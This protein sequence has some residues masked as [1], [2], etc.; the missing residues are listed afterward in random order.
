MD[1]YQKKY[2]K[3][4]IKY[5]ILKK[6]INGGFLIRHKRLPRKNKHKSKHKSKDEYK[7]KECSKKTN[8]TNQN[9]KKFGGNG[10]DENK[11]IYQDYKLIEEIIKINS[12]NK[13]NRRIN[14]H[15]MNNHHPCKPEDVISIKK[16]IDD[17]DIN[18]ITLY[19]NH[20]YSYKLEKII[21]DFYDNDK[22]GYCFNSSSEI[23]LKNKLKS[24][25][26]IKKLNEYI[27]AHS[28]VNK[29]ANTVVATGNQVLNIGNQ[30]I[31]TVGSIILTPFFKR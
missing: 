11:F 7:N 2:Y 5:L 26:G 22:Y 8:K 18:K 17:I 24:K 13:K 12:D 3:Y 9:I 25:L 28:I 23:Y 10:N 4:L 31:N 1:Y 14:S 30:A 21:K 16:K 15:I 6:N 20:D 19:N 27:D 29:T